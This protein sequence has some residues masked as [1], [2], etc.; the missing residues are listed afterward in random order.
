MR[1]SIYLVKY[2]EIYSIYFQGKV[3]VPCICVYRFVNFTHLD[4]VPPYIYIYIFHVPIGSWIT[5]G[6]VE[7]T[8]SRIA[9]EVEVHGS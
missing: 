3:L 2:F 4:R 7:S 8:A 1:Y 9:S 6:E 5:T